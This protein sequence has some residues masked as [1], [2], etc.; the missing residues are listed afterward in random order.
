MRVDFDD[1]DLIAH[2][3]V[4][5]RRTISAPAVK[6]VEANIPYRDGAIDLT[7][8]L[9]GTPHFENRNITLEFEMMEH[10]GYWETVRSRLM[11][12]YHGKTVKVSFSDDTRYYWEGMVSIGELDY[13]GF[14]CG[15]TIT[16]SVYP[17]KLT[18][19][20]VIRRSVTVDGEA[21]V[22]L[23][24]E[25]LKGSAVFTADSQMI[26]SDEVESYTISPVINKAYGMDIQQGEKEL[27][28]EGDGTVLIE[29]Y[30]GDL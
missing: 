18:K 1:K 19:R 9:S 15:L 23:N 24:I 3:L 6:R 4:L 11:V 26:V 7:S 27:H 28:F 14:T 22:T 16:I 12:L 30:G 8:A 21:D 2:H 10:I 25:N 5:L 13:H 17:F 20:P 29:I